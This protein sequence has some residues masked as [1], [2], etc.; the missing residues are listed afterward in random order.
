MKIKEANGEKEEPKIVEMHDF[1]P[2]PVY[3]RIIKVNTAKLNIKGL[4]N[5]TPGYKHFKWFPSSI[6]QSWGLPPV[7]WLASNF[8]WY[9]SS[10][11]SQYLAKAFPRKPIWLPKWGRWL[12]RLRKSRAQLL[13]ENRWG[14]RWSFG[15]SG[16]RWSDVS[17]TWCRWSCL[18]AGKLASWA[19][20]W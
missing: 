18:E 12:S 11:V 9:T 19:A 8:P 10:T 3:F 17:G 20:H 4:I 13:C 16:S 6:L 15:W 2:W 7:F 5:H 14:Y 1:N